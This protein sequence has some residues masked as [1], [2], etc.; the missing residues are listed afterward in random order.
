MSKASRH[1]L[2]YD[3]HHKCLSEDHSTILDCLAEERVLSVVRTD[4]G[5]QFVEMCDQYYGRTLSPEQCKRFIAELQ[6]LLEQPG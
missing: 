2:D 5:I 3:W 4:R 6:A 1:D